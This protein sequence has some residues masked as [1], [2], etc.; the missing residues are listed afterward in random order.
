M[1]TTG[2]GNFWQDQRQS[3]YAVMKMATSYFVSK[4]EKQYSLKPTDEI[5]DY[6]CGPGFVADSL[7]GRDSKIT[8]AD[9][10]DFFIA[11][12]RKNHPGGQFMVITTN[13]ADNKK[14]LE[15]QLSGRQFDYIL[16]LSIIQYFKSSND[17][18]EVI[19]L[20]RGYLKASG[21]LIIA[22]VLDEN[23]SSIKDAFS[24]LMH[25]IRKGRIG[26]FVGFISYLMF[27]DYR[28]ISKQNKLLLFSEET[29]RAIAASNGL[30]C[31]KVNGL[32]LQKSRSNYVLSHAAVK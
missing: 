29:I 8:G 28:K 13:T 16:L 30:R 14:I 20:L 22:D 23:T 3:F 24:L 5:F 21:K 26:A 7:A 4:F 10:N 19:D 12:C 32:T 6:G 15:E 1:S 25:C 17:L 31:E 2:W 27:S 9:I 11:E 18:D